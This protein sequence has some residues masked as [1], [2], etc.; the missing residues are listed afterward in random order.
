VTLI[1]QNSRLEGFGAFGGGVEAEKLFV[2][3]A[4]LFDACALGAA[5]VV[6]ENEA[7]GFSLTRS[8]NGRISVLSL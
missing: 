6:E 5:E 8:I 4:A 3:V 1:Q 7:G 2:V